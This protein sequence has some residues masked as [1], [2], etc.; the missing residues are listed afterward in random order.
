M[1]VELSKLESN[2]INLENE[3]EHLE[4]NLEEI[5]SVI[6][7]EGTAILKLGMD[8]PKSDQIVY[9]DV[10]KVDGNIAKENKGLFKSIFNSIQSLF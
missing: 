9:I 8:Y 1:K 4:I 6:D 3:I 2:R 10:N 7:I 5:K